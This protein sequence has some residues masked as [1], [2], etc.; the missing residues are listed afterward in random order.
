M[1]VEGSGNST[2]VFASMC[3]ADPDALA[4]LR[5]TTRA[6]NSMFPSVR[7]ASEVE[8]ARTSERRSGSQTRAVQQLSVSDYRGLHVSVEKHCQQGGCG[9]WSQGIR[10]Y[11]TE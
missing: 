11:L 1:Q 9:L 4:L 3:C 5:C 7:L 6:R 10:N 2:E 8:S